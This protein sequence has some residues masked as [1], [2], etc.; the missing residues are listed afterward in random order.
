V[1]AKL[2]AVLLTDRDRIIVRITTGHGTAVEDYSLQYQCR[3]DDT[4]DWKSVRRYDCSDRIV[5]VH[6]FSSDGSERRIEQTSL[7]FEDGLNIARVELNEHWE[8]FRRTYE[9][10]L[11][12]GA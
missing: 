6:V 12:R 11:R 10:G 2:F 1:G 8:Q 3:F 4:D 9:E 7:S 5:H